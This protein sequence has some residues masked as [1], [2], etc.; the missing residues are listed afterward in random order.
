MKADLPTLLCE[1]PLSV[2]RLGAACFAEM[3]AYMLPQSSAEPVYVNYELFGLSPDNVRERSELKQAVKTG[4]MLTLDRSRADDSK[5]PIKVAVDRQADP[6]NMSLNGNL[7]SGRAVYFGR[8]FNLKGI[9]RTVLATSTDPNHS[10]GNLDLVSALWEAICANVLNTNLKTGSATVLAVIDTKQQIR[11][12]WREGLYPGGFIIRID[13]NGELDRPTHLFYLNENVAA[14]KLREFTENLAR[15]DAEKF[16]ERILHGCWS[17][18][19]VSIGGHMIDYDTVFALRSRAPQWSYRPNWLSNFFGIEGDGQKKLLKAMINH[20]INRE[21]LSIK[22]V[23]RIF[24]ETRAQHLQARFYDLIGLDSERPF[25]SRRL[26]QD[27]FIEMTRIFEELSMKMSANFKA[28][29]PWDEENPSLHI[30]DFSNFFRYAPLLFD[31]DA[32]SD[33]KAVGLIRNP[34]ARLCQSKVAG[35]PENLQEKMRKKY[36]VSSQEELQKLDLKALR[37]I[38]LYKTLLEEYRASAP[39]SWNKLILKAFVVNEER[40]Y[41]NCRPGNDVLVALV[42]NLQQGVFKPEEFSLRIQTLIMACDRTMKKRMCG[43]CLSNIRLYMDGFS[44]LMPGD[45]A[46]FKPV[47]ALFND[48]PGAEDLSDKV[49]VEYENRPHRCTIESS[50]EITCIIGPE[51]PFNRL[52]NLAPDSLRF[53]DGAR[54]LILTEISRAKPLSE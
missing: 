38:T 12:P 54:E 36:V 53:F 20:P 19:N 21:K 35:M 33:Q 30:F 18:G 40:T 8:C 3:E 45:N 11:V 52:Y 42:Q 46:M 48:R 27:E 47:L 29:A 10:N 25:V 15:Q 51:F 5:P 32:L 24:D 16:I 34:A 26:S 14:E 31:I 43:S 2:A 50:G 13:Q 44:A 49:R 9:G 37:F 4:L 23:Y 28:T 7:G 41:M 6:M 17:A 39:E 1:R 22:E